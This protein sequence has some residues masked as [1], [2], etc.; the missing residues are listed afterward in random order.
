MKRSISDWQS[1]VAVFSG[2]GIAGLHA[3]VHYQVGQ[4]LKTLDYINAF[5]SVTRKAVLKETTA[6]VLRFTARSQILLGG[7]GG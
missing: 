6:R 7:I 5:D 4:W 3:K 2:T 1:S